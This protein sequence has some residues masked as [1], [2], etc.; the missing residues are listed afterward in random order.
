[1]LKNIMVTVS[2]ALRISCAQ[3]LIQGAKAKRA[4]QL[5]LN[6]LIEMMEL[7]NSLLRVS[8]ERHVCAS[9]V[10]HHLYMADQPLHQR[11][12]GPH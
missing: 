6:T 2:G 10:S 5:V 1:M 11:A 9:H 12:G 8:T 3:N 4:K 7:K